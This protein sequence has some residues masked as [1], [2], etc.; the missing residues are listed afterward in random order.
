MGACYSCAR[1][2]S[3]THTKHNR[4]RANGGRNGKKKWAKL[5]DRRDEVAHDLAMTWAQLLIADAE[6]RCT[7]DTLAA[8]LEIH[9]WRCKPPKTREA[10]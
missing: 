9:G 7:Q 5:L 8:V 6:Y 1:D 4:P 10:E 2:V 3:R